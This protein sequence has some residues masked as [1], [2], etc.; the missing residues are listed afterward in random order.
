MY[1]LSIFNFGYLGF[2][3]PFVMVGAWYLVRTYRLHRSLKEATA[4]GPSTST[5]RPTS[6]KRYTPPS[7]SQKRLPPAKPRRERGAD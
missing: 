4:D 5:A 3:V 2:G 6:N 1:G 7:L